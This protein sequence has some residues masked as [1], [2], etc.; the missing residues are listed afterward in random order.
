MCAAETTA[1]RRKPWI[2]PA[3]TLGIAFAAL[4]L[5]WNLPVALSGFGWPWT[6]TAALEVTALFALLALVPPLRTGRVG[7]LAASSWC[8]NSPS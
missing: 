3:V 4:S 5:L 8:P 7:W 2:R 6:A 1:R